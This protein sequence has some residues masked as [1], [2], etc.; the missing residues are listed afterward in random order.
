[1]TRTWPEERAWPAI[2]TSGA[3]G[4]RPARSSSARNSPAPT[5]GVEIERLQGNLANQD[6]EADSIGP[7]L[8]EFDPRKSLEDRHHA[9]RG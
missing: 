6:L 2:M 8:G 4:D 7:G 5:G 1:M 9:Q 3:P